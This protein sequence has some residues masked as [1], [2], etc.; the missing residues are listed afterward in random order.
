MSDSKSEATI[1]EKPAEGE[2]LT[3]QEGEGKLSREELKKLKE[4]K[5]KQQKL[6]KEAKEKAKQELAKKAGETQIK[7][8]PIETEEAFG[9]LE[10]IQS[11][12]HQKFTF[13]EIEKLDETLVGKQVRVRARVHTSREQG[14]L[15]FITLRKGI[16]SCQ[17]VAAKSETV[18]KE[19]LKYIVKVSRESIVDI[20]GEVT[21]ATE[22]IHGCTQKKIELQVKR[23]LVVSR[24]QELP[25]IMEDACRQLKEDEN[26]EAV[27]EAPKEDEKTDKLP[28]VSLTT[29]LDN[30]TLDLRVPS[31]VAIFRIQSMV[32]QLFREYLGLNGF[33][34]IHSPKILGGSSEGGTEV[35]RLKY[36]GQ[37]A[38]L[39]QS[40]QLYKQMAI[41]GEFGKVFEIGPVFRAENSNTQRHLCEFTGLDFEMEIKESYLEIVDTIGNLFNHI[42]KG[43]NERCKTELEVINKQYPF[44]PFQW[45][46]KFASFT[47]EEACNLLKEHKGLIQSVDEDFD[48]KNEDEFGKIV[49]EHFKTDF[50]IV[51]KY[52]ESARPFYTMPHKDKGFTCSY[53][54]FMRGTEIISGAQRCHD[55]NLLTERIKAKN[56]E[57]DSIKYYL[58]S[59]KYGAIPHGGVGVGL[60]R[61][62]KLFLD[63]GNI[64]KTSLFPRDPARL[65]P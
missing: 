28:I 51:H 63:I 62:V 25:F 37:D 64:R 47:F 29:R 33:I 39:A 9:D 44:K 13:T 54:V 23:F 12:T 40:P 34:E 10:M 41:L 36:F 7:L 61:V 45:S 55:V 14:N 60:E 38:S 17:A 49:K 53:D 48:R 4:E 1:H 65:I 35:F 31:H 43:I 15:V 59:F 46:D 50:Y 2:D 42:F 21:A 19:M 16:S 27:Q 8:L 30:R 6:E 11:F 32:C 18:P 57:P 26:E 52:P 5:K 3:G 22:D 58:D 24:A 20:V 56:I